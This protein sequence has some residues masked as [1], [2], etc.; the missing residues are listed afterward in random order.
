M[1]EARR[2][3]ERIVAIVRH[4]GVVRAIV[5]I[6]AALFALAIPRLEMR[7]APE[8]LV[9]GDDDAARDAAAIARDFGAQ[10]QALVVLVEADDVLAPDVLAWSHSMARF[11]E[12]QRGVMRVESLGTTPLPR[13]TRDDE[14][15]LEALDDV[16]DAQ[17]V[18]A[19][20]A[21]TAAVASDPE[22]FPAGL[23]SLAERGRGPVEVR[24]MVAGDAPTEVER[25]AIEALV[26]SSGLLRGR[27]ISEDRRVTVI[28][29]VLGS[30]ASERDAEALV[31]S[32][33]ARIAAQAPPAGARARLAG[34]PAMRVSMID[35]LRTDQVLLVSLAVLGSLLVLMLGM[36]TRG[37]VLLP[38]GTVGI[39]LAITMGGMALAG[40]PINLLTN[41]I[42][43]LLVTI[44]L[45]DSLHLVI[46]Y[47]EELREGAP[48]ARTAASR[49]L[50]HMWLPCFVTSFTTA[51]GFGALVVQGTP[52]LV[53][54][55]A[56]AAI[57]SMTSYLV[58][59]V[60]V[61]A[62]L[63]SFPGE[64]K[65]SLEAGRMSRGL[66]RAIVLLARANAR[67]PRMTIA[68]ASVLMIVSLVIA[69]GV[70]V[71]SRLLDQFGVGSEIAQV[72]RVMEEELDGVRE[73]SIA[74]D[75]D[76]GRF[77]TPEGIA[78]LESLS[79][80]LRDQEGVLRATTIADWLHESWVLV[81]GEET[82]RSEPF[83]SDAQVRALRA[84]LASGGVDPLDAFVTD[85]GRRARIE[86]RLLDHGA[87]RTLAMLER[88]RARA[89]EIDGARVSFGGE[90]WI[91]SRGLERIVAALGGLGSAVVVIFFVMT[92]LFR[93]VRLG[94]LSIPPNAL[95]LA[96]TLAYMVLRGIPL[97]AATVIVFTVTVGLAVD[98]ATHVIARF[99]EQHA[100]GG[101]PEQILLRTM[102][103]SGRAVVLSALTL[104]L[105]Y[106]ALLFSAFEPIRLF[107]E[108]SFVAIGGALIAQLVLLPA[109]LA[110]GVPR[111]GARAAGDALASER[112]VAE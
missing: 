67:H 10:E 73:L 97:H 27:M 32:T 99:R 64:A 95:P 63:P 22:R 11:L 36:R 13:P 24:P 4:R 93:S 98:G 57:A 53:R 23:A 108:L 87:R 92:L 34:L 48:D 21:I 2:T 76:D 105:G 54:F 79:R 60:F 110:V 56:I 77:A 75:A 31:A 38:M 112:S 12:S 78:Q 26:A 94:L 58:A 86:V 101:T 28:A 88:F 37:G 19:E 5:L 90:A 111:E 89:D 43:P 3:G 6:V 20:D 41:V 59:I 45:A 17:R 74:L 25:A 100:L 18:R 16:E 1:S 62:S 85:D 83:R 107:G 39:T 91:A 9:A 96:M 46:R 40:E 81:T 68:V 49:M 69:R 103:T 72:T 84:L 35:A 33:S 30:D 109:L 66:D 106:G 8:E 14:L 29:A 44:G 65:V 50:R 71:D 61:P 7:F 102:E 47:R 104:L 42:P 55:G 80:W 51:V 82:A 15:T 70:V 52:I